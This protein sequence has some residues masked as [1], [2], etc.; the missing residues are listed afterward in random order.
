M[1]ATI[2]WREFS[3]NSA[4]P[5]IYLF[6]GGTCNTRARN[7]LFFHAQSSLRWG[8]PRD[9][10]LAVVMVLWMMAS[11]NKSRTYRGGRS[12]FRSINFSSSIFQWLL[13]S[14]QLQMLEIRNKR[15]K[16]WH[17]STGQATSLEKDISCF[18][19][20]ILNQRVSIATLNQPLI[21]YAHV[22]R[23][24]SVPAQSLKPCHFV[25]PIFSKT[26]HV[27]SLHIQFNMWQ[28]PDIKPKSIRK[29][30]LNVI[31]MAVRFEINS[32]VFFL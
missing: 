27:T 18:R 17:C 31:N 32:H 26:N 6:F 1:T 2:H 9:V 29:E 28:V 5:F 13:K 19:L 15:R 4:T 8:H 14:K 21:I 22:H 12:S 10:D 11:T 25:H 3:E 30:P 20:K 16:C 24:P 23:G 7:L